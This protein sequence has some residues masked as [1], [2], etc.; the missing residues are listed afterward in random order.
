MVV[1]DGLLRLDRWYWEERGVA[2]EACGRSCCQGES[3]QPAVFCGCDSAY[4]A[5]VSPGL[6][7]YHGHKSAHARLCRCRHIFWSPLLY[8]IS[9]MHFF[10]FFYT[11]GPKIAMSP[12]HFLRSTH[13]RRHVPPSQN[14]YG[15]LRASRREPLR[16]TF[17]DASIPALPA[18][19]SRPSLHTCVPRRRFATPFFP[20]VRWNRHVGCLLLEY[21]GSI[22]ME[23]LE[24]D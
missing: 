21:R 9:S 23:M 1:E 7:P 14:R 3:M 6:P 5:S 12:L 11:A 24:L 4:R 13:R 2:L 19:L 18:V 10:F 16:R 15:G 8:S 20:S 17:R 22:G